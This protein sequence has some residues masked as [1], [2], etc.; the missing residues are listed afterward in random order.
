MNDRHALVQVVYNK[1]FGFLAVFEDGSVAEAKT[2]PNGKRTWTFAENIWDEAMA[3][4]Q[5]PGVK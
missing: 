1:R 4:D 2:L 5:M 3:N